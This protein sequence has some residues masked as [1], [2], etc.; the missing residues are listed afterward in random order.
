MLAC[1]MCESASFPAKCVKCG[2]IDLCVD[3]AQFNEE[4]FICVDCDYVHK[5]ESTA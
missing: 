2:S 4:V 5:K 1:R 3:Y